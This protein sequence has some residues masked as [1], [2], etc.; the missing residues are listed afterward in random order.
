MVK[1]TPDYWA[2]VPP[3]LPPGLNLDL[4]LVGALSA[5][6]R[7]IG[8]LGGA[9]V[10]LP[11]PH[12]LIRPF[13]RREAVLSS[14]IEGTVTTLTDLVLFEADAPSGPKGS[15]VQEVFNYVRALE[16]ATEPGRTLPLS[17][18][19]I[20]DVHRTLMTGVRGG[21]AT[22]GEFR[23]SQNWV[24]PPGCLLN[25][26]TYVPPPV[27]EMLACMNAL[28]LYLHEASDIP[29][30]LRVALVHYQFEGI[31]PF[32]D[33]NGRVGRLLVSLLLL[34]WGLLPK[35]LLYLSAFFEAHR[36]EYYDR[37]LAVS[38]DGDWHGWARFFLEGVSAESADVI[39]RAKRLHDLRNEYRAR[40]QVTRAS[41]L[42]L[43]L[44]D[45]LFEQP[46]IRIAVAEEIL[47]VTFRAASLNVQKLLD[48][49]ILQ[50]VTGRER[51]RVF[52]AHEIL[53]LL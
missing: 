47:G 34:E 18:R 24:G 31:H 26:A 38:T 28:E 49:G 25:E 51:N 40:L 5:A 20:R 29:P 30:L 6:D 41:A 32:L 36:D 9:G 7:A 27:D 4:G 35:P 19:L 48:A 46:A 44:V 17:L 13:L 22:P 50:E 33:G 21:Y 37:L 14:K 43:R 11:E 39:D 12:L 45:H 2:F 53:G 10:W 15:D 23:R 16:N 3:P 1:A 8:E 52:V 42:L